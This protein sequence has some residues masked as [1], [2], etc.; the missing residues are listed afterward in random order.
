MTSRFYRLPPTVQCPICGSTV[1]E[2]TPLQDEYKSVLV[3]C[4][5]NGA[6]PEHYGCQYAA[7][8][9]EKI[10][11]AAAL[12]N[13]ATTI[14]PHLLSHRA[15]LDAVVKDLLNRVVLSVT[16]PKEEKSYES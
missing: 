10:A 6:D 15:N 13:L 9:E 14:D 12:Q 7:A 3:R 2:L 8:Q 11:L 16:P 5:N 4:W 1:L